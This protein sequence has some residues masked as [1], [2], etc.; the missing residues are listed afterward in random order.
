MPKP[1]PMKAIED[2]LRRNENPDALEAFQATIAKEIPPATPEQ[3]PG[4]DAFMIHIELTK[5]D[6]DGNGISIVAD[7]ADQPA[8]YEFNRVYEGYMPRKKFLGLI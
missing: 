8:L 2:A 1:I 5:K 3:T 6:K 7:L 4:K